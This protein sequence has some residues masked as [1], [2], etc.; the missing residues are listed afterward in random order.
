MSLQP[1][2]SILM[3]HFSSLTMPVSHME[4]QFNGIDIS[5]SLSQSIGGHSHVFGLALAADNLYVA[6]SC[7]QG[8]GIFCYRQNTLEERASTNEV[9]DTTQEKILANNSTDC[10]RVH[11]IAFLQSQSRLVFTDVT[12]N[13]VKT[14]SLTDNIVD[15]LAGTG[16]PGKRDG[17]KPELHQPTSVCT[18]L[19]TVFFCDTGVG[20]VRMITS[21]SGLLEFLVNLEKVLTTF[22]VHKGGKT[23]FTPLEAISRVKDV[24]AFIEKCVVE[25]RRLAGPQTER[26]VLQGPDGVCSAHTTRDIKLTIQTLERTAVTIR[27]IS[28]GLLEKLTSSH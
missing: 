10:K 20:K 19:N 1:F 15:C 22:G 11:G 14:L 2:N 18:E 24:Y 21:P 6:S 16:N 8:G 3:G 26:R 7:Q 28:P 5:A 12:S 25:V 23:K 13:T 9:W 27:D 17:S 4:L